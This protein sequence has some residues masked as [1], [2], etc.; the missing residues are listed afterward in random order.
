LGVSDTVFPYYFRL[1]RTQYH[2]MLYRIRRTDLVFVKSACSPLFSGQSEHVHGAV[3]A[4]L[5]NLHGIALEWIGEA[6]Q[7]RLKIAS[8]ST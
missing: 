1:W 2:W 5:G 6:G 3:D 7:A 8:T 4:V